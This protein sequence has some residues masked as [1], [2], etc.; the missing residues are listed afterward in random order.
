M[1]DERRMSDGGE[2]SSTLRRAVVLAL[3]HNWFSLA[4]RCHKL[5]HET[6]SVQF[7]FET[8]GMTVIVEYWL[9]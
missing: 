9:P 2:R 6:S 8:A 3:T 5:F 4:W 7:S 1:I